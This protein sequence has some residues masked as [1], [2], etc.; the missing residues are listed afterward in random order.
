MSLFVTFEGIEGSGKSTHLRLLANALRTAGHSVVETREPGGTTL[1]QALRELLLAPSATP[2]EPLAELLLY[3]ADRA[4]HVAQVIRPALAAGQVVLCDRFSDSTLAYQGYA[5]SLDLG[6]VRALDAAARGGIEPDLTFLLDCPPDAGLAR[7][8]ARSGSSDRF[9]QEALAFHEAVQRGFHALA[10]A[11]PGRYRIIDTVPPAAQVAERIRAETLRAL[12]DGSDPHRRRRSRRRDRP[13]GAQARARTVQPSAYL[14][15]GPAGVGK[16]IPWPTRSRRSCSA[17]RRAPTAPA[18]AGAQCVRVA[19]GRTRRASSSARR[20]ARHPHRA[21]PR[22][23]SL[24]RPARSWRGARSQS[25]TARTR[26]SE[27]GQNALLK[28]LEEPPGVDPAPRRGRSSLLR[29][30]GRSRCQQV[31]LDPLTPDELA[32]LLERHGVARA[33]SATLVAR[34][35]GSPGRALA[36]RED[37]HGEQRTMVLERLARLRDLSAADVSS[38]AQTLA[39]GDVEPALDTIASWYRD[40][41]GQVAGG[42]GTPRNPE[43]AA[44]AEASAAHSTVHGVLRQLEAV[45]AT[46]EAIEGNANKTLALETLLL[47]LRRIERDPERAPRWTT[48]TR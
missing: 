32:R 6:T 18:A 41:L 40:L 44:A 27:H 35:A 19:G 4:Q 46:I 14:F 39:R 3:C 22:P 17:P 15:S 36:L 38:L 28:T 26:L 7:A 30:T 11:T 10:A 47:D 45:C 48:S 21:D 24:A 43:M 25:S 23:D 8:R 13:A 37:T 5:R 42:E 2:P 12:G 16:R 9:E 33:E 31:R 29:P 1:G 34:A 20:L